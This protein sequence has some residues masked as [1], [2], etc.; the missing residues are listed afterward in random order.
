MWSLTSG[1][2]YITYGM[3][4]SHVSFMLGNSILNSKLVLLPCRKLCQV[5]LVPLVAL[6][7]SEC[8]KF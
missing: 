8:K 6:S 7:K 3:V 5:V 1:T 2:S 4:L